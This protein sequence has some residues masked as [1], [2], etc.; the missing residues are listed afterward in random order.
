MTQTTLCEEYKNFPEDVASLAQYFDYNMGMG[1]IFRAKP[2]SRES[3]FTPAQELHKALTDD[4]SG[5]SF[6]A[7]FGPIF[8]HHGN[9][10]TF[11]LEQM[12]SL[13][14]EG[15]NAPAI[16][17]DIQDYASAVDVFN[18]SPM[19]ILFREKVSM[20]QKELSALA[21][22]EVTYEEAAGLCKTVTRD[23]RQISS[24]MTELRRYALTLN[25]KIS[26]LPAST[27]LNNQ[28][29]AVESMRELQEE[30]H[31]V[32]E[33]LTLVLVRNDN[34]YNSF[35][36]L[37]A[38][39]DDNI[40]M[41]GDYSTPTF[42]G[43]HEYARNTSHPISRME[44]SPFPYTPMEESVHYEEG[45]ID[46]RAD[47]SGMTPV[48]TVDSMP[49]H[50]LMFIHLMI[51]AVR[52]RWEHDLANTPLLY[53]ETCIALP[54]QPQAPMRQPGRKR[55]TLHDVTLHELTTAHFRERSALAGHEMDSSFVITEK[56]H[57]LFA[58]MPDNPSLLNI[59]GTAGT[60]LTYS[61]PVLHG[62]MEE[63]IADAYYVARRNQADILS[64]LLREQF[65]NDWPRA[66]DYLKSALMD[67]PLLKKTIAHLSPDY[68]TPLDED[69]YFVSSH[70]EITESP[71]GNPLHTVRECR[72]ALS[73]NGR[74]PKEGFGG[75][76]KL[77]GSIILSETDSDGT[78]LCP[79]T[80]EKAWLFALIDLHD[81]FGVSAMCGEKRDTLPHSLDV[82]GIDTCMGNPGLLRCDPLHTLKHPA[83]SENLRAM[84]ALSARGW[85]QWRESM[86]MFS[87]T[88]AAV[89][90]LLNNRYQ[91]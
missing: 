33:G 56:A 3:E 15:S 41:Y 27:T 28:I 86:G 63:V 78:F 7:H 82:A 44:V 62:S 31:K 70:E 16:R 5:L 8:K 47:L 54:G 58:A 12:L 61:L 36:V 49:L 4:P 50:G 87:L 64:C 30:G 39:H 91:R 14:N 34:L 77:S 76:L 60:P 51:M 79:V 57:T 9:R 35:F 75:R 11:S 48:G 43:Q 69:K 25:G 59:Q 52:K 81:A 90:S 32:S 83:Q 53:D 1:D 13:R 21:A 6:W 67:S 65:E 17:A 42:P 74:I 38:R 73:S 46:M 84:I 40:I 45:L 72:Y 19:A 20:T 2:D 22:R 29:F 85:K 26:Q 66:T 18:N 23:A 24:F 37:L 68:F 55:I 89:S 71:M 88:K 80:G 10:R